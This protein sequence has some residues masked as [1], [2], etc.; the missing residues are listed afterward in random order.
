[1]LKSIEIKN[2]KAIQS[3]T[4]NLTDLSVFVG[5][6]GS[7]KS[8]VIEALQLL[9]NALSFGL[10]TAFLERWY[11]FEYIR[12][13][14]ENKNDIELTLCV[15]LKGKNLTYTVGFNVS[16]NGDLYLVSKE[17]LKEDKAFIIGQKGKTKE[18]D[19][20]SQLKL[21]K[22]DDQRAIDLR[23][24]ISSWQFL[25]LEPEKMYRPTQRDY[26]AESVRM[27]TSGENL[28]IF[29]RRL[30]DK[31]ELSKAIH[32]KLRYVLPDLDYVVD[33]ELPVLKQVYL[34]LKEQHTD[35]RL[36]SWLFSS[37]T[38]RILTFLSV[39][40]GEVPPSVVFIEEIENG[41]DPRTLNLLVSEMQ[42]LLPETQFI[43]TTHSPYFLDLV[44]L[45]HVIVAERKDG[46]TVFHRPDDD[47]KLDA[48]KE[49]FSAGNLYTMNKLTQ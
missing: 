4:I 11:G 26:S 7:G 3:T 6:N 38:L 31:P 13:A 32:D 21:C 28:A 1:M 9:Q 8:S 25:C 39:L 16:D 48:W 12:N 19:K 20:T 24:Y 34:F 33:Y 46:N 27:K 23:N 40:N 2:F 30:L 45:R 10:S 49:K 29:Y 17:N 42:G 37:G 35:R 41:L 15:E 44:D 14:T 47:E 36:Q 43:T 18:I 5:N 22:H